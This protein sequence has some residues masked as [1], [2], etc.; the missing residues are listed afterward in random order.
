VSSSPRSLPALL[1]R[2]TAAWRPT[3]PDLTPDAPPS[4]TPRILAPLCSGC[5]HPLGFGIA[6]WCR[7][8]E[9]VY[10]PQQRRVT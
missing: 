8:S 9:P 2:I 5:G 1:A 7:S 4:S 10:R 6:H 3:K